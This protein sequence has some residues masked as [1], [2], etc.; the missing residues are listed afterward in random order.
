MRAGAGVL[1][2]T[3]EE[4]LT[5]KRVLASSKALQTTDCVRTA[6]GTLPSVLSLQVN[7]VTRCAWLSGRPPAWHGTIQPTVRKR[8]WRKFMPCLS[9]PTSAGLLILM[10]YVVWLRSRNSSRWAAASQFHGNSLLSWVTS[11]VDQFCCVMFDSC[12]SWL[13]LSTLSDVAFP[14]HAGIASQREPLV[15]SHGLALLSVSWYTWTDLGADGSTWGSSL[16]DVSSFRLPCTLCARS[17]PRFLSFV[18]FDAQEATAF[19]NVSRTAA[20]SDHDTG[21]WPHWR[22]E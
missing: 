14:H 2:L 4:F 17:S 18:F 3:Y 6:T 11:L 8:A 16:H 19:Y 13:A 20:R 9:G 15:M 22:S 10:C 5:L 7:D 12:P 1:L 21:H